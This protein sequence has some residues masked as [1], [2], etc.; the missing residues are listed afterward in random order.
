MKISGNNNGKTQKAP[1]QQKKQKP[2]K[3]EKKAG[4]SGKGKKA[5]TTCLIVIGALVLLFVFLGAYANGQDDIYSNISVEGIDVGGLTAEEAANALLGSEYGKTEDKEL[6]VTLPAGVELKVS[7]SKAGCYM[8]APD[9]AAYAFDLCHGG[10][11]FSNTI[12]YL[13]SLFGGIAL[14]SSSGAELDEDY[15]HTTVGEAVGK[16]Q[17]ALMDNSIEIGEENLSIVKGATGVVIDED[18]LYEKVKTRLLEADYEPFSYEAQTNGE[19]VEEVDLAE[20]YNMVYQEPANAEYDPETKK[21]TEAV[22][23]RSFDM[24]E[25][26]KL[27]D[28][29]APGELVVIPLILTEPEVT[30]EK[31]NYML[32]ADVLSQKSTSLAGSSA[33]RINN[34]TRAANSING[35]ILN[36]GDE[37]SYNGALG[38][39]TKKAGYQEAGA[40]SG[41]QVVQEV[42]GGI[43]QVSSTLYYCSL[44]AN[45][46]ITE[47]TCHYFGVNYLPTGLDATV[48]WP[49][50]DFKFKNSSEYP[51]KIEATV[52]T[53]A[54]TVTVKLYGSNPDGIRVEMTTQSYNVANGYGATTYRNVY[55]KDGKLISSKLEAKSVY[56]YHTE[57]SPSPSPSPSVSPS[58]SPSP[59]VPP[60]PSQEVT[61]SPSQSTEPSPSVEPTTPPVAESPIV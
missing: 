47:R 60:T 30:T 38:Q 9:A 15:L 51:I 49:S 26:Q 7:A 55:D 41:G 23:G 54:L 50:P 53:S 57:P 39:R 22:I 11:F 33:A 8:A 32:F 21:A 20:I 17:V 45:L 44:I 25:A 16:A 14:T 19:D 61:P 36:P 1:K 10:N 12:T 43:C 18:D 35:I 46:E 27:W 13:R 2:V 31:L 24:D 59:S 48:S 34:I 56:H 42:G 6:T 40:Y 4:G 58:P 29:A 52:N 37:F 5:L 28:A 3:A